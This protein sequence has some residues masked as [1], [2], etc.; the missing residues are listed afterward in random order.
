MTPDDFGIVF[1][2]RTNASTG[3]AMCSLTARTLWAASRARVFRDTSATDF[4][5]KVT[6]D[7]KNDVKPACVYVGRTTVVFILL[8]DKM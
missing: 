5:A 1:Q 6:R 3:R 2:T 4:T 8:S 7:L